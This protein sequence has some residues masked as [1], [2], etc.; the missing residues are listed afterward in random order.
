MC[1]VKVEICG[2]DR[3]RSP[4]VRTGGTNLAGEGGLQANLQG[5]DEV[6]NILDADRQAHEAV[7][8]AELVAVLLGVGAVRG[9][10]GQ[11]HE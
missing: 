9:V 8:H 6:L 2:M 10:R 1:G 5:R 7:V 4:A 3:R 11:A